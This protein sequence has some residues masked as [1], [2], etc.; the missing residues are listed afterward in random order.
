MTQ[1]KCKSSLLNSY[2]FLVNFLRMNLQTSIHTSTLRDSKTTL[3][4]VSN[5]IIIRFEEQTHCN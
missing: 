4:T 2:D 3:Q 1:R 5:N